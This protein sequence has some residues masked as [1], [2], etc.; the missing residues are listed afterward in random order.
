MTRTRRS[1][2]SNTVNDICKAGLLLFYRYG[3]TAADLGT[4]AAEIG[5]T[6]DFLHNH[7][8]TKQELLFAVIRDHFQRLLIGFEKALAGIEDPVERMR[9]FMNFHGTYY[10]LNERE[11]YVSN[12]ELGSLTPK[13][14][15]KVIVLRRAYEERVKEI[16]DAG[17]AQGVFEATDTRIATFAILN[18]LDRICTWCRPDGHLSMRETIDIHIKLVFDWL[19]STNTGSRRTKRNRD[20]RIRQPYAATGSKD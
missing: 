5:M 16:M 14:H 20:R 7:F 4:L 6:K 17:V 8:P 10:I 2:E 15:A 19:L 1:D 3:Y 18:A 12:F 13:N 11:V 9:A